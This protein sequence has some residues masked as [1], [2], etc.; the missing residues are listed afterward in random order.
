MKFFRGIRGLSWRSGDGFGSKTAAT[1]PLELAPKSSFIPVRC[2]TVSLWLGHFFLQ[3]SSVMLG[4]TLIKSITC[5][6]FEADYSLH[7][8]SFS[9]NGLVETWEDFRFA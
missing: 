1:A 9:L 8:E 7:E 5:G 4:L 6:L 2:R 3:V